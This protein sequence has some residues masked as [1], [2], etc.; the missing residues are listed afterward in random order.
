MNSAKL[1]G[2]IL[3]GVGVLAILGTIVFLNNADLNRGDNLI[4]SNNWVPILSV[5]LIGTGAVFVFVFGKRK[6]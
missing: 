1:L 5:F 4:F 6:E 2:Y 3:I